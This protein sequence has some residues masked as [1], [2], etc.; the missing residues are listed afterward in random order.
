[1]HDPKVFA[2]G[3]FGVL[4][5]DWE[6]RCETP[7][8]IRNG[9]TLTYSE[10]SRPKERGQG[11]RMRW[12]R[13]DGTQEFQVA[14]LHYGP[15]IENDQVTFVH[16]V[17]GS[18]VRGA[19]RGW[20]LRH[21]VQRE[22]LAGL[23][24]PPKDDA[25]AT[26]AYLAALDRALDASYSSYDLVFSL[27]GQVADSRTEDRR[28]EANAGRLRVDVEPFEG[29]AL[30]SIDS[31][32]MEMD[33]L[34]GPEN[35][36]RHMAVRSPIDRVTQATKHGGLHHFLE[37]SK[38]ERFR[39]RLSISNPEPHDLGVISLWRREM[40]EGLLRFGALS[41]VGRGRV[42]VQQESYDLWLRPEAVRF[43]GLERFQPVD[44]GGDDALT[45]LW[46]RYTLSAD[47]LVSFEALLEVFLT[48]GSDVTPS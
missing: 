25:E 20:T 27:F 7:L 45:G 15:K 13:T 47:N 8:C 38:G 16:F 28:L 35:V 33:V 30:R 42:S 40:N 41:S 31:S 24:P 46:Q 4:L 2:Q 23:T 11:L 3:V 37:F 29:A 32:G 9:L 19:L 14:A 21:L 17:P 12:G 34:G 18:S 43:E 48:G 6:L 39:V 10:K 36:A 44:D 22:A 1:M 5:V 26:A